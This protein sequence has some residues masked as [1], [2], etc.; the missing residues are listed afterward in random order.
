[1]KATPGDLLYVFVT[2][3]EKAYFQIFDKAALPVAA[4]VP[5]YSLR[6]EK[7]MNA[8]IDL[9]TLGDPFANGIAV[10][11]SSNAFAYT[12]PPGGT[13][14]NYRARVLYR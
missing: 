7:E 1:V 12:P 5:I 11:W 3:A 10:G 14:A 8:V 6:A 9:Q 2:G 13:V 4:E